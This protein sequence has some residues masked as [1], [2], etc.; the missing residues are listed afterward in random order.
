MVKYAWS[1]LQNPDSSGACGG[2]FDLVDFIFNKI[3][4]KCMNIQDTVYSIQIVFVIVSTQYIIQ[5]FLE[6]RMENMKK[7]LSHENQ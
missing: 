3:I 5:V 4:V 6:C 2:L 7:K 1:I